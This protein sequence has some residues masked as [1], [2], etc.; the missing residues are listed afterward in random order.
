MNKIFRVTYPILFSHCDPAGIVYYPRFFDL[1]HQAMEEWFNTALDENFAELLMKKRLGTPTVS[2]HCDFLGPARFGDALTIE[3]V[4]TRLGNSSI[5][6][7][8]TANVAGRPCLKCRHTICMFSQETFKAIPIP[9][10]LRERMQEYVVATLAAPPAA[11]AD[12]AP[13]GKLRAVINFGNP[14]L[15][16]ISAAT[17]EPSGVSVDLARELARRLGV[18]AE[19]VAV[20]SA[21]ESVET[22]KSGRVDVGFFAIDP[23]RGV[24]TAFTGPYVQIEGAYLVR[25]D[26][27]L[28]ANEEVDREGTRVA[29]G[30]KS[31]YDLFLT[32]G[33]KKATIA[34]APTSP[35]VVDYFVANRLDVAAGVK[36]QLEMDAKRVPGMRLLPGRFMVINQAMG[37][38]Q[39]REAGAKYLTAFVEEMKA[40]GFVAEALKRHGIEGAAVAPAGG[41]H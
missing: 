4:I 13:T 26:S 8:Y 36:Q 30:N 23:V 20:P 34:R 25:N 3:L 28:R 39:G 35:A 40:S 37:M 18:A 33:L 7:G 22:L 12:L 16:K 11:L 32:R 27:P 14:I 5:E 21:G 31:A 15:A 2:T 1:L 17:G 6:L 24:D 9:D 38:R 10:A 41:V 19:L 29:V